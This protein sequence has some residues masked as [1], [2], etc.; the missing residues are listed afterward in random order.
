MVSFDTKRIL[1]F[2]KDFE[3]V[4]F[5]QNTSF[6]KFHEFFQQKS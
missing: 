6:S 3:L 1:L 2:N 4:I 5:F